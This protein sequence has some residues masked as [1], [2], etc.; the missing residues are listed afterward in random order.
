MYACLG[1][2][3][4]LAIPESLKEDKNNNDISGAKTT[5]PEVQRPR[6]NKG[7]DLVHEQGTIGVES[8]NDEEGHKRRR[9]KT[10]RRRR[11][12]WRDFDENDR[13]H[14]SEPKR[15]T[16][17]RPERSSGEDEE[18]SP[19]EKPGYLEI[20]EKSVADDVDTSEYDEK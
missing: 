1:P 10:R 15:H 5:W 8:F 16:W 2:E 19:E 6:R 13:I 12:R 18:D 11:R 20:T 3:T 14:L 17:L 9:R 7:D 4:T